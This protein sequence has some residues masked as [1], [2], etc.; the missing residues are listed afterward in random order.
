MKGNEA[1]C[2]EILVTMRDLYRRHQQAV[3]AQ[4]ADP[5]RRTR[6]RRAHLARAHPLA[7]MRAP[8]PATALIGADL[9]DKA[10]ERLGENADVVL[11]HNGRA[12]RGERAGTDEESA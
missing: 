4:Q 11:D 10:D 3:E 8:V 7:A 6:W 5:Q 12:T 1:Q 9:R 2:Q